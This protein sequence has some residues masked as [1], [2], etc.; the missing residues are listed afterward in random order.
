MIQQDRRTSPSR[1]VHKG[2][3]PEAACYCCLRWRPF[4]SLLKRH[5]SIR[6]DHEDAARPGARGR[7]FRWFHD[8]TGTAS[9]VPALPSIRR[10]RSKPRCPSPPLQH[11]AAG[12]QR[13]PGTVRGVRISAGSQPVAASNCSAASAMPCF[14]MFAIWSA[15]SSLTPSRT[16]SR[17]RALVMRPR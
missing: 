14:F 11:P 10:R 8:R 1:W 12:T 6:W 7:N 2:A 17:I 13:A 4:H 9:A 3:G 15:A 5:P 16:A